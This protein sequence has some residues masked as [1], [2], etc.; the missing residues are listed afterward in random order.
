[1]H[2]KCKQY[3]NLKRATQFCKLIVLHNILFSFQNFSHI[4]KLKVSHVKHGMITA[5]QWKCS[6]DGVLKKVTVALILRNLTVFIFTLYN[7]NLLQNFD[8]KFN[9]VIKFSAFGSWKNV[10]K[11][12]LIH[13]KTNIRLKGFKT[14]TTL[15]KEKYN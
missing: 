2:R 10:V 11:I 6:D 4:K 13:L 12:S 14:A 9:S 8:E 7:I 5:F 1:M 3:F 15:D